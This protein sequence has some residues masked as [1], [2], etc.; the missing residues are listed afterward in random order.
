MIYST[1]NQLNT[2]LI[3]IFLGLII[4]T[5]FSLIKIL[6]FEKYLKNIIK[7]IINSVVFSFFSIFLIIFIN[8]LNFGQPSLS[9]ISAYIFGIFWAKNLFKN[10][11]V[12]LENKWYTI[13][14]KLFK[15]GKPNATKYREN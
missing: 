14:N 5:S 8:F 4:G 7:I 12:F 15:K 1:T 2:M 13:I 10:L 6:I 11:V 3:F 9:L